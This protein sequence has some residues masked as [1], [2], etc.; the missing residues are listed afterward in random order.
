MGYIFENLIGR[1]YQNVDAG[2]FYTGRDIIKLLCSVLLSEGCDDIFDDKKI[3]TVCD[4]ACGTGGMLSTAFTYLEKE[5]LLR[6][7]QYM[8]KFQN[9]NSARAADILDIQQK[10][11]S[12]LLAKAEKNN[13][14]ESEGKTKNKI[15][16]LIS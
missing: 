4:Q 15:Y 1:F 5:R 3:I 7:Q 6:L 8:I 13:F 2:Q 11:A 12:R 14:L 16:R 9:I 10:T